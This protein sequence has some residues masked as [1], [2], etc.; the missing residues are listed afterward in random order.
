MTSHTPALRTLSIGGATYDFFLSLPASTLADDAIR[1]ER[2]GKVR[3]GTIVETTG[4]GACNTS[5]GFARL[6]CD[7]A[8]CGIVGA[9]QWGERLIETLKREGV[10]T[11]SATIVD[12]ETSSF[13]M[14]LTLPD[15]ERTILFS[16]GAT[17]HLHDVTLDKERLTNVDAIYLNHLH[18]ASCDIVDD[19]A[20]A[21]DE[22]PAG[23]LFWNPGGCQIERG[24]HDEKTMRLLRHTNLL[25]LNKEEALRF[26]GKH[27]TY[28]ALQALIDL[29]VAIVCIT[30]G[31]NGVTAADQENRWHCPAPE[32]TCIVDTTGAGDAFG[33]AAA[34]SLLHGNTLPNALIAGTL[35]AV[36]VLGTIGA[37]AGLLTHAELERRCRESLL[38]V[39]P[40]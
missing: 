11:S 22:H 36:S 15:G 26:T 28:A 38:H 35:N 3:V 25:L 20:L 7:A 34:W 1:L 32:K 17:A 40:C 16:P 31:A 12:G 39:R 30:D 21:L 37:Q 2:G 23:R 19:I 9:D 10:E 29:G 8:F 13:S 14:I 5:V 24:M 4:G 18:E 27:E 6:G 33:T